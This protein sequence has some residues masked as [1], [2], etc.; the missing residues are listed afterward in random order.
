MQKW[1]QGP[2]RRLELAA[3]HDH[4]HDQRP[5]GAPSSSVHLVLFLHHQL[6]FLKTQPYCLRTRIMKPSAAHPIVVKGLPAEQEARI[7]ESLDN[8]TVGPSMFASAVGGRL[9]PTE[10]EVFQRAKDGKLQARIVYE[11]AVSEGPSL[12]LSSVARSRNRLAR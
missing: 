7:R 10:V 4:D 9:V 6:R 12:S 8:I 5:R 11:L 3:G 1:R 2:G